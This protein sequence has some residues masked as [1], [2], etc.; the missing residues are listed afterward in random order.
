MEIC[1]TLPP[2]MTD[3]PIEPFDREKYKGDIVKT[4]TNLGDLIRQ[5]VNRVNIQFKHPLF[6]LIL[7]ESF[8]FFQFGN[9]NALVEP[10]LVNIQLEQEAMKEIKSEINDINDMAKDFQFN[11][12][13]FKLSPYLISKAL[14]TPNTFSHLDTILIAFGSPIN[15]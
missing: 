10:V 4:A 7:A 11:G 6:Q 5:T 14:Q 8:L 13:S 3:D 12:T 2:V 9:I 15:G 1:G